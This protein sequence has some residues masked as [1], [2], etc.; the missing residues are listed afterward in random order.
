[1]GYTTQLLIA[2]VYKTGTK[3]MLRQSSFTL[4]KYVNYLVVMAI[5]I[6]ENCRSKRKFVKRKKKQKKGVINSYLRIFYP[7][8]QRSNDLIYIFTDINEILK[9]IDESQKS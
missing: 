5:N 4:V 6:N 2:L 8:V 7:L 9:I 3:L 1:M